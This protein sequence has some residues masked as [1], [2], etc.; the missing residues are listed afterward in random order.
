MSSSIQVIEKP[1]WVTWESVRQCLIDAHDNN[2]AKGIHMTHYL[3]SAEKIKASLGE[4]GLMLIAL[5][6]TDIIG[7]AALVFK[8]GDVWYAKGKYA[9]LCFAG[10]LP[11]YKGFGIYKELIRLREEYARQKQCDLLLFDTHCRNKRVQEI[12]KKNGYRYVN[13][14]RAKSGDHYNVIMAKWINGCPFSPI[15][16]WTK[17]Q[18]SKLKAI[19][20]HFIKN[21][22]R[23]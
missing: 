9:Y 13:F 20:R 1:D 12:A 15:Y 23:S 8:C 19:I 3:W 5:D 14:F 21:A 17:Y 10:V 18:I 22:R 7:T 2:R 6:G 11:A 16:C 4:D